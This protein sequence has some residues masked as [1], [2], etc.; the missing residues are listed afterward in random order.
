MVVTNFTSV[1]YV[2]DDKEDFYTNVDYTLP[3]S[4]EVLDQ[5]TI[6]ILH[7]QD[8]NLLGPHPLTM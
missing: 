3:D 5:G 2:F 8:L 1:D 6:Q 4:F 7:N